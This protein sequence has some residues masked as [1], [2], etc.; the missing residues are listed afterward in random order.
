MS[1]LPRKIDSR[2]G[3]QAFQLGPEVRA[4]PDRVVVDPLNENAVGRG[5]AGK[6]LVDQAIGPAIGEPDTGPPFQGPDRIG[7]HPGSKVVADVVPVRVVH[8]EFAGPVRQADR[9]AEWPRPGRAEEPIRE[10]ERSEA[11]WEAIT[12][13]DPRGDRPVEL[14]SARCHIDKLARPCRQAGFR[15]TEDQVRADDVESQVGEP[16]RLLP[17]LR[18]VQQRVGLEVPLQVRR[19]RPGCGSRL[20]KRA[21]LVRGP[22]QRLEELRLPSLQR[23]RIG[24]G[25]G[26]GKLANH[27]GEVV[28]GLRGRGL[29]PG[30]WWRVACVPAAGVAA[31]VPAPA[32]AAVLTARP[33]A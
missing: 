31:C 21:G 22:R 7:S 8:R 25:Q 3:V 2:L 17:P 29:R 9:P 24:G 1:S 18:R 20:R 30:S 12:D 11:G 5:G 4:G 16:A 33:T 19:R 10:R 13:F 26:S 32:A 15:L 6:R 28:P 14:C 27:L 23:R